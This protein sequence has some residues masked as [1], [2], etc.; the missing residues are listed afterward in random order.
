MG[1]R[2]IGATRGACGIGGAACAAAGAF[3]TTAGARRSNVTISPP[4]V[5]SVAPSCE[6]LATIEKNKSAKSA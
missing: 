2:R 5:F 6:E 3:A 4:L 1:A